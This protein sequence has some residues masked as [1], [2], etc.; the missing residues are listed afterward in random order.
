ML[1]NGPVRALFD[2]EKEGMSSERNCTCK[3]FSIDFDVSQLSQ[4]LKVL[5]WVKV[6]CKQFC[7]FF[8]YI[9]PIFYLSNIFFY[10]DNLVAVF[11]LIFAIS[12]PLNF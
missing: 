12:R 11:L 5:D 10:V 2:K 8:K 6:W 4:G 7:H 3:R 9:M 1:R